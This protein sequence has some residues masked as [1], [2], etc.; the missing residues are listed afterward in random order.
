MEQRIYRGYI[1]P[2]ALA[3]YLVQHFDPQKD[4][5]AQ[6]IGQGGNS[7]V[8]IGRGDVPADLRNAVTV[9]ITEAQDDEPGVAVTMGQQQ[10]L[11]PSKATFAAAIG[12]VGVLITP[13][14]LFALLWPLSD[15]VG[16]TTLP[17]EVWTAIDTYVA[18]QGGT[19]GPT[20]ELAHPH[21]QA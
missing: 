18:A 5:Q 2:A 12:L 10:W 7:I 9:A 4:L 16:S 17:G 13:L 19:P 1:S 8:Q 11:T 20:Q 21:F 3:E 14:A 15:L 6:Q